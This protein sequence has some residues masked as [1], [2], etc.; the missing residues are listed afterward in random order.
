M[1]DRQTDAPAQPHDPNA[2]PS[3]DATRS[4]VDRRSG[5]NRKVAVERRCGADRRDAQP[6]AGKGKDTTGL[7]RL[8]G[9]GRRRPEFNRAAE[10]GEF[11]D[12]QFLFVMAIEAFKRANHKTF[13][14]WTE[15]LEVIRKL[16]YRKTQPSQLNLPNTEDWLEPPD[17]PFTP[18]PKPNKPA[19]ANDDDDDV[20]D[21]VFDA[22]FNP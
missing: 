18:L 8:R 13:P 2:T 14:N 9:P 1:S 12:E 16:G 10:E 7:R 20:G 19:A 6:P 22:L 5:L 17:A 3:P 11:T 21:D 4:V 15:V